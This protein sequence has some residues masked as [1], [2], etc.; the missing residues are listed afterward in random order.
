[1]A[2][3]IRNNSSPWVNIFFFLVTLIALTLQNGPD[4]TNLTVGLISEQAI[5][6]TC[7]NYTLASILR[8]MEKLRW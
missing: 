3:V 7:L 6:L 1:M 5:L 8:G 4:S 2:S